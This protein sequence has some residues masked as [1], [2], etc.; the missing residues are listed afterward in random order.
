MA[1]ALVAPNP[2]ATWLATALALAGYL[3]LVISAQLF[4]PENSVS[5]EQALVF[6]FLLVI[7][8]AQMH[9]LL[10]RNLQY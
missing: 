10:G 1:I 2:K 3:T 5:V 9:L 7:A 8:G 4:A 6:S